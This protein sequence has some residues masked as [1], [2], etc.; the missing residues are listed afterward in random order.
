MHRSN[1]T[2]YLQDLLLPVLAA[3]PVIALLAFVRSSR[4]RDRQRCYRAII[5][6]ERV[7]A[8]KVR[9]QIDFMYWRASQ[10]VKRLT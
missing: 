7:E 2:I 9:D 5:T 6:G 3:V 4:H 10:E 8:D 1:M